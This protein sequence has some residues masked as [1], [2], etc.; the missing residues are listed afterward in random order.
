MTPPTP[1]PDDDPLTDEQAG[2][3][4]DCFTYHRQR[5]PEGMRLEM[6][7]NRIRIEPGA[8]GRRGRIVDALAGQLAEQLPD[9]ITIQVGPAATGLD[10]AREQFARARAIAVPDGFIRVVHEY[11]GFEDDGDLGTIHLVLKERWHVDRPC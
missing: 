3:L 4:R 11:T 9:D 2:R 10:R 7:G 8:F 1:S 5:L 6:Y